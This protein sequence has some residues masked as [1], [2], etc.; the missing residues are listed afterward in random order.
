M[1]E[2]ND[3]NASSS[4]SSDVADVDEVAEGLSSPKENIVPT[5][6]VLP[7]DAAKDDFFDLGLRATEA[8]EDDLERLEDGAGAP[9]VPLE[10]EELFAGATYSFPAM[11]ALIFSRY[12]CVAA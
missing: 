1:A 6:A 7:V 11:A 12:C 2:T 10:E 3:S 5:V 8:D 9:L 4:E